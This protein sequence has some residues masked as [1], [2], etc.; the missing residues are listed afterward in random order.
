MAVDRGLDLLQLAQQ[1]TSLTG[2]N[3][4]FSTLPILGFGTSPDGASVNLVDVPQIQATVRA[5]LAPPAPPAPRATRTTAAPTAAETSPAA[6]PASPSSAASA[7]PKPA[8]TTY[9]DWQGQLQGGSVPC[10]K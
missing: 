7:T 4:S 3:I 1:A 6:G 2:G 8:T 5:L 9:A 10:V